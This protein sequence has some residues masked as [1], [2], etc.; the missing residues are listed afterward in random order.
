VLVSDCK[1]CPAGKTS[2]EEGMEECKCIN[3]DSCNLPI[4]VQVDQSR[5]VYNYYADGVDFARETLPYIG[6]W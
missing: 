6:R 4:V 3:A 2:E 1:R 5:T